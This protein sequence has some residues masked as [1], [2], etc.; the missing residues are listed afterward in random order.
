VTV[1]VAPPK[2]R[3]YAAAELAD[4][5]RV[6]EGKAVEFLEQFERAGYA[7][8]RGGYWRATRR[9]VLLHLVDFDGVPV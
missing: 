3:L 7:L 6:S 5:W 4:R 1:A 2:R 8:Q 9:A